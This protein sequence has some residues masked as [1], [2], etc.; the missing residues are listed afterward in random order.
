[1]S[2]GPRGAGAHS[3]PDPTIEGTPREARPAEPLFESPVDRAIR[4]ATQRGE[5]DNLP[6]TGKPLPD[7]GHD[8]NWWIRQYVAREDASTSGFL[9]QSLLL[10]KEAQD[11]PERVAR[12]TSEERVRDAVDDLN[13]R[14]SNEIR[15]PTG[16]PPLAMRLLDP[17][18][19]VQRWRADRVAQQ[20][21]DPVSTIPTR[22]RNSFWRRIFRTP[23]R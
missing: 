9:P 11:L 14:I 10:R 22:G 1:M 21:P 3:S 7:R 20:P 12:L 6:G 8:E 15:M 17:D 4:E 16:G 18:D 19:V 23:D 5:F 13:R 2:D